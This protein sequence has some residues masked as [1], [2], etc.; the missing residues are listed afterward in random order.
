MK[1]SEPDTL[2]KVDSIISTKATAKPHTDVHNTFLTKPTFY[3]PKS[4]TVM[5]DNI[6][7]NNFG[8]EENAT[9]RFYEMNNGTIHESYSII[10]TEKIA[11]IPINNEGNHEKDL[12]IILSDDTPKNELIEISDRFKNRLKLIIHYGTGSGIKSFFEHFSQIISVSSLKTA[13]NKSYLLA[14]N[15]QTIFFPRVNN[16]FDFFGNIDFA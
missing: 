12:I 6:E 7:T 15:G 10:D 11:D 16:R 8:K 14:Q 4:R 9:A 5:K 1:T 3:K 2:I 13:V